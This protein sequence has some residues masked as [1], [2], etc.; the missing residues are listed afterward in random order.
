MFSHHGCE[1]VFMLELWDKFSLWHLHSFHTLKLDWM[2]ILRLGIG[3]WN[4]DFQIL[5]FGCLINLELKLKFKFS[6]LN[7]N[8]TITFHN[9][10]SRPSLCISYKCNSNYIQ[11]TYLYCNPFSILDRFS[12]KSN[13]ILTSLISIYTNPEWSTFNL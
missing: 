12:I 5:M 1:W 13:S 10:E 4:H 2:K 8:Y 7:Y 6:V 11:T 9:S 3:N